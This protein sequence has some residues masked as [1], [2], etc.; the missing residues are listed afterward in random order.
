MTSPV[1]SNPD[2]LEVLTEM[3][4]QTLIETG[5]FF[6]HKGSLQSRVQLKRTIPAAQ[7]QFQSALDNL[8]EQIFVA[9]AFLER[10]YE[11]VKARKAAL[12]TKRPADDVVMGEA[13]ATVTSQPV[14]VSEQT[15]AGE[16]VSNPSESKPVS[17]TVKIEQ[18]TDLNGDQPGTTNVPAKEED[19]HGVGASASTAPDLSGQNA[20]ESE[21]MLY[22]SMLNNPEPNEFDLNLDFGDNNNNNNN[23]DNAGNESF[24]NTTF[25][26][27]NA[28]SGLESVNTQMPNTEPG[29]DSNALPTG[30][31]AFDLELQKFSTQSG[32]ANEQFGG[33]TEDIMGPGESSFDDLFMESENMGGN[34]N[35]DQDLLGGDGL[36]Q[37]NE[38][39]DNWFT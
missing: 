15:A 21:Q 33:N 16:I 29:Q 8:S 2:S 23:N 39:D 10:D 25:G 18:Q 13:K 12:R 11:V 34:D 9:K 30:G 26:D 1:L 6:Q 32:D 4:N 22:N 14:S 24:F 28:N 17:D 5:R 19:S 3:V 20:G 36:M 37:L 7:E 35:N 31:D 38:L 27:S